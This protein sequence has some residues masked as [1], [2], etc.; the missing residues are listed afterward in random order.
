MLRT[1]QM[2]LLAGALGGLAASP[3]LAGPRGGGGGGGGPQMSG[4][5]SFGGGGPTYYP[6]MAGPSHMGGPTHMSMGEGGRM[7]RSD[8]GGNRFYMRHGGDFRTHA[9][10]QPNGDFRR[11]RFR[12]DHAFRGDRFDRR[13][14]RFEDR[15]HRRFRFRNGPFIYFYNGWWYDEPWWTYDTAYVAGGG[16]G[17]A[18]V[19][20][21]VDHYRSYNPANNTFVSYSGDVRECVSPYGP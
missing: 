10:A 15:D 13:F 20:W 17:D 1:M 18:H 6:R 2:L 9:L 11:E 8:M 12:G 4:G 3:A 7:Y 5:H 19:Q 21:C 16:Y 14:G